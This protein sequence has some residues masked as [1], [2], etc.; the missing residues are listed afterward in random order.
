MSNGENETNS[1]SQSQNQGQGAVAAVA[2]AGNTSGT[3]SARIRGRIPPDQDDNGEQCMYH[4]HDQDIF[5]Y[6]LNLIVCMEVCVDNLF[7]S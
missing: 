4:Q 3:A 6:V 2:A 7:L 1:R 5:E